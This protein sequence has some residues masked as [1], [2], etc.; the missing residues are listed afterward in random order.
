MES[1][2][3]HVFTFFA[4]IVNVSLTTVHRLLLIT[5]TEQKWKATQKENG[6]Y[7]HCSMSSVAAVQGE[8]GSLF[9]IWEIPSGKTTT[10]LQDYLDGLIIGVNNN[11]TELDTKASPPPFASAFA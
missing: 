7:C 3:R 2:G 5:C 11:I 1:D 4:N 6:F 10:D 9:C 8:N